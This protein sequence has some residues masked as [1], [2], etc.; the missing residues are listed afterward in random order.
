[1]RGLIYKDIKIFIKS[2][3]KRFAIGAPAAIVLLFLSGGV[4]AG[5]YA[6]FMFAM[7]IG[8]Q[9]IMCFSSDAQVKWKKYEL[10][11]PVR[12]LDVVASKYISVVYTIVISLFGSMVFNAISSVL[13]K[14]FDI[15]IWGLSMGAAIVIP[16]IW[17]GICLPLTYWFGFQSA[18]TLGL[19]CVIPVFFFIKYFEDGPGMAAMGDFVSS[20]VV[21]F[22]FLAIVI[23]VVSFFISVAGYGKK[24]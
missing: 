4:Y 14:D 23:F 18:Q 20:Y 10:A 5:V 24:K 3:D 11:M 17:T 7:T 22:A 15:L 12:S 8:M 13:F 6:S 16:L 1:M 19:F 2:I 9:N 21:L